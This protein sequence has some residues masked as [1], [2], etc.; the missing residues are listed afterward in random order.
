M[1]NTS[2][3]RKN[4]AIGWLSSIGELA[5]RRREVELT[6]IITANNIGVK[7]C[8]IDSRPPRY[9][10]SRYPV[11]ALAR[12]V[13]LVHEGCDAVH[14]P[15]RND[16]LRLLIFLDTGGRVKIVIPFPLISVFT[17]QLDSIGRPTAPSSQREL[18]AFRLAFADAATIC[19]GLGV[20]S[21]GL[22][23]L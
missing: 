5:L 22:F 2:C 14:Q 1:R 8:I 6:V 11:V 15:T 18:H 16:A 12:R 23:V 13:H 7:L 20:T 19:S 3:S 9:I 10:S 21:I 4:R 17:P